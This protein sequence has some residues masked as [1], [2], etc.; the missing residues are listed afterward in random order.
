MRSPKDLRT[1]TRSKVKE[2]FG[3]KC[4]K[5]V[6]WQILVKYYTNFSIS[7]TKNNNNNNKALFYIGFK[8]NKHQLQSL[9]SPMKC[10]REKPILSTEQRG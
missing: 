9:V 7:G 4:F 5:M 1:I 3:T 6:K 8:N 2:K 10:D